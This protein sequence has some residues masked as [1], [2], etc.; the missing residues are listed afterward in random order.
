MP[1][2]SEWFQQRLICFNL[3]YLF[4]TICSFTFWGGLKKNAIHTT[5]IHLFLT[6]LYPA[7]I[8][9]QPPLFKLI[10][11]TP[12]MMDSSPWDTK[13]KAL[14]SF[15][16]HFAV[17]PPHPITVLKLRRNCSY[18]FFNI[19]CGVG[20]EATFRQVMFYLHLAHMCAKAPKV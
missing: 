11:Y 15:Y 8:P 19:V 2:R 4:E 20:G 10:L 5:S 13:R 16:K 6:L 9:H 3:G 17:P 1:F 12:T 7:R 18:L 14:L